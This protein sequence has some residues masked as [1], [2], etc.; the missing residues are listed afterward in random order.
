[1][2]GRVPNKHRN[3]RQQVNPHQS[4]SRHSSAGRISTL[5]SPRHRAQSVP[6]F[7]TKTD[8][9]A[10][11]KNRNTTRR[12]QT[13]CREREK[14]RTVRMGKILSQVRVG[15]VQTVRTVMGLPW[16][17]RKSPSVVNRRILKRQ[18]YTRPNPTVGKE[19]A[20]LQ[21]RRPLM[22]YATQSSR[23]QMPQRQYRPKRNAKHRRKRIWKGKSKR[24]AAGAQSSLLLGRCL[25]VQTLCCIEIFT[26]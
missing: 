26:G 5:P 22:W 16:A 13:K 10:E 14:K 7:K 20:R 15:V 9:C 24:G 3:Q 18:G 25:V 2:L 23:K 21:R 11:R 6:T 4:V 12:T 17:A 19:M 8:R 1:M